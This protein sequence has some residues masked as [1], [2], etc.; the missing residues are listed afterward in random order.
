MFAEVSREIENR[1][2]GGRA[3]AR[4]DPGWTEKAMRELLHL[5]CDRTPQ[6]DALRQALRPDIRKDRRPFMIVMR[7]IPED[8]LELYLQRL[9]DVALPRFLGDKPGNLTPLTWPQ[10]RAKAT[11]FEL[12]SSRLEEPACPCSRRRRRSALKGLSPKSLLLTE[13]SA[14]E[15]PVSAGELLEAYIG[16]W[17]EWPP[18]PEGTMLI[19]VLPQERAE[20]PFPAYVQERLLQIRFDFFLT[21]GAWSCRR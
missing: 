4:R 5:W 19:P 10:Y 3:R 6:W 2:R 18:L 9:R 21:L 20:E 12:F 13:M 8:S 14:S 16:L 7:G 17:R 11:P 1:A 15:L